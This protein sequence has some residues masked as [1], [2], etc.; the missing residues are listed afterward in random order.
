MPEVRRD[1]RDFL[2]GHR[3]PRSCGA[4]PR[5]NAHKDASGGFDAM[6]LLLPTTAHD[7]ARHTG[8]EDF[9]SFAHRELAASCPWTRGV[10]FNPSCGATFEPRRNWQIYCCTA[11]ERAGTAEL[12]KW[13]HRMALPLL[14]WRM[15]KYEQY[16]EGIRDL[17]RAARRHVS[18]VQSAWLADRHARA[19]GNER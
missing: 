7:V 4:F 5:K 1:R 12:R 6:T 17:T 9:R 18:Q 13:G 19:E 16:D 2:F 3:C 15:G 14:I 10:C 8:P 11:C